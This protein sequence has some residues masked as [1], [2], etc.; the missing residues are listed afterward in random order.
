MQ[1]QKCMHHKLANA[2]LVEARV[3]AGGMCYA[4]GNFAISGLSLPADLRPEN[5]ARIDNVGIEFHVWSGS[6]DR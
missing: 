5:H 4:A 6:S 3:G 2:K 1:T